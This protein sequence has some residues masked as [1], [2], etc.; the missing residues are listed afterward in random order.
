MASLHD[1]EISNQFTRNGPHAA[2]LHAG[3][4]KKVE[5]PINLECL[6]WL[7][8]FENDANSKLSNSFWITFSSKPLFEDHSAK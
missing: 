2:D 7:I 1:V 4:A 3:L 8:H 6:L 5:P